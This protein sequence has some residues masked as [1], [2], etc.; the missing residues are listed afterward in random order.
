MAGAVGRAASPFIVDLRCGHMAVTEQ[1]LHLPD[2]DGAVQKQR[3]GRRPQRMRRAEPAH[4]G[5][6]GLRLIPRTDRRPVKLGS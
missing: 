6:A 1:F 5:P 4:L 3:G 2:I